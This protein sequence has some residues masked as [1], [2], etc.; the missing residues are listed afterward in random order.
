MHIF[1]QLFS[2]LSVLCVKSDLRF[3]LSLFPAIPSL[4]I[5]NIRN[6]VNKTPQ[7][8]FI[9][10]PWCILER[11]RNWTHWTGSYILPNENWTADYVKNRYMGRKRTTYHYVMCQCFFF[12]VLYQSVNMYDNSM[13]RNASKL[14]LLVGKRAC[15]AGQSWLCIVVTHRV[16]VMK[17][18][19]TYL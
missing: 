17:C 1:I 18:F 16:H 13:H 8:Y 2:Q 7:F 12:Y 3:F 15:V 11:H 5:M 9:C 19:V 4:C 10:T 14:F 6:E